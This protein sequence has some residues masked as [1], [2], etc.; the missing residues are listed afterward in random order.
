MGLVEL[1][2]EN[3]F[4]FPALGT[5]AGESLEVLETGKTWAMGRGACIFSH[6]IFSSR[7]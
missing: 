6:R 3:L 5:F 7:V 1:I 2:R 4:Y